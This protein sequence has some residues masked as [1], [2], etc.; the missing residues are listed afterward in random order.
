MDSFNWTIPYLKYS[1]GMNTYPVWVI[2]GT[3]F[4]FLPLFLLTL[5]MLK[6]DNYKLDWRTIVL[7]LRLKTPDKTDWQWII[8]GL[9]SAAVL[10]GGIIFFFTIL[11][12]SI[13]ISQLKELSPIETQPLTGKERFILLLL[14]IFFFFNYVGEE[15]LWRGYIL[16]RQELALGK[17]SWI[18]NGVLH[19]VFH[20]SFGLIFLI[21]FIPMLLLMPFVVYKT[22]NTITAIIIHALLGVPMQ[23]LVSLGLI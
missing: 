19:G 5:F 17:Y 21:M 7:R 13:D 6:K 9:L 2:V 22:K 18:V 8:F 11:P 20:L 4:L 15:I 1:W 16:P 23:V 3:L 12:L 10:V 14:P